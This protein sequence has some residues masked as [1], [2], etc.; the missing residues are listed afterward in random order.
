MADFLAENG[1]LRI[2]DTE[3]DDNQAVLPDA[4]AI[5][6]EMDFPETSV[7]TPAEGSFEGTSNE[8]Y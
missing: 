6:N 8:F 4:P 2:T 1:D 3:S 7:S 5:E